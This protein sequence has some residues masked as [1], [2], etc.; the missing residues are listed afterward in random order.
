MAADLLP[1]WPF[2]AIQ[3]FATLKTDPANIW[4]SRT[5]TGFEFRVT[6]LATPLVDEDFFRVQ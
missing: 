3:N 6:L 5:T 4:K 2:N 1:S